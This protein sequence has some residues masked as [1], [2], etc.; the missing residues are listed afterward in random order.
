MPALAV[1]GNVALKI[2]KYIYQNHDEVF[3]AIQA[4]EQV[5]QGAKG[6]GK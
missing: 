5:I 2:A 3:A 1:V 4:V 6:V